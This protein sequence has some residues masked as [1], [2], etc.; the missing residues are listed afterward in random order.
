MD[1]QLA[2]IPP[3]NNKAAQ[4]IKSSY[5]GWPAY[6]LAHWLDHGCTCIKSRQDRFP[7]YAK[8]TCS[9]IPDNQFGGIKGNFLPVCTSVDIN[10]LPANFYYCAID[11]MTK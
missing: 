3:H 1:A 9:V 5:P 11:R 10:P 7:Y 2:D 8:M 4:V 6:T